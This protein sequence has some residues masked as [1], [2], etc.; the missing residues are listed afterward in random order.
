[1]P[2]SL[3]KKLPDPENKR[4]HIRYVC[5]P[6]TMARLDLKIE[7]ETFTPMILGIVLN[8]SASG[9]GLVVPLIETFK[10]GMQLRIQVGEQEPKKVQVKWI[11]PIDTQVMRIGLMYVGKKYTDR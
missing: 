7:S 5:A 10:I 11:F 6:N 9:C 3:K 2:F 4:E 1:M 8:E